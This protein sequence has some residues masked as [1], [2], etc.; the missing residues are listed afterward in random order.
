M[1]I[2]LVTVLFHERMQEP[3]SHDEPNGAARHRCEVHAAALQG[4]L[5]PSSDAVDPLPEDQVRI[6]TTCSISVAFLCIPF[7]HC[8][9]T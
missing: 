8:C 6:L 5:Q 7:N 4:E 1:F 3:P 9:E 2:V